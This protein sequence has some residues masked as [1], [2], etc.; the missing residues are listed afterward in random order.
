MA[1]HPQVSLPSPWQQNRAK[2]FAVSAPAFLRVAKSGNITMLRLCQ[3]TCWLVCCFPATGRFLCSTKPLGWS[4]LT[5]G[6]GRGVAT[7]CSDGGREDH[8]HPDNLWN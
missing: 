4:L 3:S 8:S 7:G 1:D 5:V 6:Q 2:L